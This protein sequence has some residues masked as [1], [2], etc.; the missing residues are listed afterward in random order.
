MSFKIGMNPAPDRRPYKFVTLRHIPI[1]P[2]TYQA[3]GTASLPDYAAEPTWKYTAPHNIQRWTSRTVVPEGGTCSTACHDTPDGT[4]GIFLRQ[5]DL[6]SMSPA[7]AEANRDLIV[8]DGSP[9]NW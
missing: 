4:E 6:D 8:P 3:W 5:S 7:E 1:A 2:E 9:V